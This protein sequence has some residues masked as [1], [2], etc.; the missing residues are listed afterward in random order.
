REIRDQLVRSRQKAE[1]WIRR[2][3]LLPAGRHRHGEEPRERN[4][5]GPRIA[6][7][8]AADEERRRNRERDRREE[9]VRDAEEGPEDVDAAERIDDALVEGVPPRSD[10]DRARD[11]DA[12]VP[13]RASERRP[14]VA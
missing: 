10:D 14:H 4:Q 11:D 6:P 3:D 8:A 1:R 13:A 5:G 9:L 2:E 7:A 12:R